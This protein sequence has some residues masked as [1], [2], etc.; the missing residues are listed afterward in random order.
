VNTPTVIDAHVHLWDPDRLRY[1][2]LENTGLYRRI[3]CT[4]LA[5]VAGTSSEF[6]A[7]QADC[8][9]TQ[10]LDEVAWLTEQADCLPAI[11]G[12]VAFAQ[13]DDGEANAALRELARRP[14]V[15]GVRQLLQDEPAGF[16]LRPDF[17]RGVAQAGA[18]GLPF[19]VCVREHQLGE[20][21]E[22]VRRT[23]Q[24][25]FVLDHLGKPRVGAADGTWH[26]DIAAL[27]QLPNVVCK[28]SGLGTETGGREPTAGLLRPYLTHALRQF[29]PDRCLFGSDWPVSSTAVG[30]PM[31]RDLVTEVVDDHDPSAHRHVFGDTARTVY[32]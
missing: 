2:W 13:L 3:D 19:D 18:A 31:W 20:V 29:G 30:Y 26:A 25:T 10:A 27:A 4:D 28:L 1:R 6:I 7:V 21:I 16:A 32:R 15:V 12:I 5:A 23:P 24:T 17:L 11:R 22:M 14:R 9:P 8:D